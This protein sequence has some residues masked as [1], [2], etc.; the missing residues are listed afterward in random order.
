MLS[1][2]SVKSL[3]SPIFFSNLIKVLSTLSKH[4]LVPVIRWNIGEN[5]DSNKL[6]SLD[7]V[8]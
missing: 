1:I 6:T 5:T 2:F 3:F 8:I 7:S 4:L